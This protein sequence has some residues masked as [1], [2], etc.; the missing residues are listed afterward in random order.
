MSAFEAGET[1]APP[2][3]VIVVD[4]F[5][6]YLGKR[7]IE[8]LEAAGY[9]VVQASRGTVMS[10]HLLATLKDES[11]EIFRIPKPGQEASWAGWLPFPLV[12][13]FCESDAGLA[14]AG[15]LQAALLGTRFGEINEARRDKF[16][17]NEAAREAGLACARQI[18]TGDWSKAREFLASLK[19]PNADAGAVAEN[20]EN[21]ENSA[22]AVAEISAKIEKSAEVDELVPSIDAV[23]GESGS[24][25]GEEGAPC[26]DGVMSIVKPSRGCA[27]GSVFLCTGEREAMEAFEKIRGTPKYGTPGAFNDEVLV[28]EFL[29]GTE[30]VVDTVSRDG[31]HKA[32]AIWKYDKREVNGAPFVYFSTQLIPPDGEDEKE[33]V[34]YAFQALDALGVKFGPT[35]TEVIMVDTNSGGDGNGSPARP[36]PT[37]VEVNTRWHLT[38]FGPLTD[39]CVGYN[40]VEETLSAYLDPERFE[41]LPRVPPTGEDSR[42]GRVVHL[43][44]FVEGSLEQI[45]HEE[46][47]R[48]MESFYGID[49]Y[50]DPARGGSGYVKKTIDIRSDA[51]WVRLVHDRAEV[52][53]RDYRRVVELMPTMYKISED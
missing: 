6:D 33:V 41:A 35:H 46:E 12:A 31:N 7:C 11:A 5:C 51:G 10:D 42:Y 16:L 22:G 30:Y 26:L 34:E 40:A 49:V 50:Q 27:S 23:A 19:K 29:V 25:N 53:E 9:A 43:V 52:V 24:G 47:I 48:N 18:K 38:D 39:A 20:S 45:L 15:K 8:I 14:N 3:G 21:K 36:T 37:L 2:A 13:V 17:M 32:M 28:Q 44:S 1:E 4:P